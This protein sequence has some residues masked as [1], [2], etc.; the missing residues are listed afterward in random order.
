LY[1]DA[2]G[3][4]SRML[5]GG[6]SMAFRSARILAS[7]AVVL[8]VLRSH[9]C[10]VICRAL[11]CQRGTTTPAVRRLPLSMMLLSG[12]GIERPL[13]MIANVVPSL[14]SSTCVQASV[15]GFHVPMAKLLLVGDGPMNGISEL[16]PA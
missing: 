2:P 3:S 7:S 12:C 1:C 15:S 8:A 10:T 13:F 16:L 4:A 5:Y 14:R 6:F 9:T 11:Y